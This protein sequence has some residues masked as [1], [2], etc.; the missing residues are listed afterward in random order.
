M[1]LKIKIDGS[2]K[3][4]PGESA[5]AA[6]VYQDDNPLPI[7][8]KA[9]YLGITTN[10]VAEH[11][12]LIL[13]LE[14]AISLKATSTLI[15]SDSKVAVNHFNG[16]WRC[17]EPTLEKLIKKERKLALQLPRLK[18]EWVG[19]ANVFPAHNLIETYVDHYR[20]MN[21]LGDSPDKGR[22]R[23]HLDVSKF[24]ADN[25]IYVKQKT[26]LAFFTPSVAIVPVW[27]GYYANTQVGDDA[28][29]LAEYMPV[30][31]AWRPYGNRVTP[32]PSNYVNVEGIQ[33]WDDGGVELMM[34]FLGEPF[35][36]ARN[37]IWWSL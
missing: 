7:T 1:K 6:V 28:K 14:L 9:K 29:T 21:K 25:H 15:E 5:C 11:E 2:S 13:A 18:V 30:I 24:L 27:T 4:N 10:N 20:K 26:D 37:F 35:H 19:R 32:Y 31:M 22:E 36:P 16:A 23:I 3:P 17:N 33:N 12:G 8:S 34:G